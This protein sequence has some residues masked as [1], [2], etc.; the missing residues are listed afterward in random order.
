LAAITV[1]LSRLAAA[2]V[3][4]HMD[5]GRKDRPLIWF[6]F[7]EHHCCIIVELMDVEKEQG[8]YQKKKEKV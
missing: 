7:Y 4:R 6:I 3:R 5:Q 8:N 2:K 1:F